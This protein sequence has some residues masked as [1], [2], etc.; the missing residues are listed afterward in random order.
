MMKEIR[1]H[2]WWLPYIEEY[3]NSGMQLLDYCKEHGFSY[4]AMYWH[5]R[6]ER[7]RN[8]E[9]FN[10]SFGIIPVTVVDAP[11]QSSGTVDLSINGINV[12]SDLETIRKIL[13]VQL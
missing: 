3:Q 7:D 13:G 11:Y 9:V 2:K 5:V 8:E 10:E 12:S 1:D 4:S 6:K